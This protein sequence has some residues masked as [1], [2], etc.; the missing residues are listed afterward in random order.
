[1]QGPENELT[2]LSFS[3]SAELEGGGCGVSC[4]AFLEKILKK[5]VKKSS[6]VRAFVNTLDCQKGDIGVKLSSTKLVLRRDS[7]FS[8]E[9][10]FC[11]S[12]KTIEKGLEHQ[13]HHI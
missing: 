4:S 1:M 3:S 2:L 11:F 5:T 9:K 6:Q 8:V 10:V 13:L 12:A 7:T